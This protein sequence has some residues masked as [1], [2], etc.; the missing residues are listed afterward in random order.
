[1]MDVKLLKEATK[2]LKS[3]RAKQSNKTESKLFDSELIFIR[4]VAIMF[5]MLIFFEDEQC[6][7]SLTNWNNFYIA[8]LNTIILSM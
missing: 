5:L 2:V 3:F 1:M 8:P 4:K 6:T 7:D